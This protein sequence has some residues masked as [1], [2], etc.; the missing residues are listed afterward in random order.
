VGESSTFEKA[1]REGGQSA[2]TEGKR[3]TLEVHALLQ[4]IHA[5]EEPDKCEERR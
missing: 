3:Q 5:A 4:F 2:G 1:I